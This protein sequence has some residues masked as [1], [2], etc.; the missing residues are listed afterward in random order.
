VSVSAAVLVAWRMPRL[1][2]VMPVIWAV[3]LL[4]VGWQLAS[5]AP[6]DRRVVAAS[7]LLTLLEVSVVTALAT[8]FSAFSSPFLTAVFTLGIFAV[9]RSADMLA[10]MPARVFGETVKQMGAALAR[11][12]PNLMAYVPARSQLTGESLT[13]LSDYLMYAGAQAVAWSVGLLAVAVVVFRRRDF[14]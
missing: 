2:T 10:Q 12:V 3:T 14:L 8:A 9:G 11:V 13:P 4:V 7:S 5:D 6:D 1:R